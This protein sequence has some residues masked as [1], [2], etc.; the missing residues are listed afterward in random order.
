MLEHCGSTLGS[1]QLQQICCRNVVVKTSST[2]CY[3]NLDLCQSCTVI[4]YILFVVCHMLASRYKCNTCHEILLHCF[5]RTCVENFFGCSCGTSCTFSACSERWRDEV[6]CFRSAFPD[7][8]FLLGDASLT[9]HQ[10]SFKFWLCQLSI[11]TVP[12]LLN[13]HDVCPRS[14]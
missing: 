6:W 8:G 3:W 14:L 1:D 7:G 5:S 10:L 2:G 11:K 4:F 12:K 9:C 13:S